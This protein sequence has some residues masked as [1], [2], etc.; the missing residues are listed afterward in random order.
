MRSEF[1][2][3][4]SMKIGADDCNEKQPKGKA[5]NNCRRR[6]FDDAPDRDAEMLRRYEQAQMRRRNELGR[7]TDGNDNGCKHRLTGING[8]NYRHYQGLIA[9]AE[10]SQDAQNYRCR[11]QNNNWSEG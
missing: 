7:E 11:N 6:S 4:E 1:E 9:L 2:I 5:Q 3:E 8:S 10:T